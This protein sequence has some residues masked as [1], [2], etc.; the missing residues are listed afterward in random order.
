MSNGQPRCATC[1]LPITREQA[2]IWVEPPLDDP[3]RRVSTVQR[4][5]R[6]A[7]CLQPGWIMVK[8]PEYQQPR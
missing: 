7:H 8:G 6:H 1:E 4:E 5:I 2:I 3:R